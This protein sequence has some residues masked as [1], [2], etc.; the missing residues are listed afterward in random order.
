M[1]RERSGPLRDGNISAATCFDTFAGG[2]AGY[3]SCV[4]SCD[5]FLQHPAMPRK[6]GFL[7]RVAALAPFLLLMSNSSAAPDVVPGRSVV[8]TRGGVVASSQPLA[9]AAAVRILDAGGN[10]AD[11][12]IAA[13]AAVGVMEPTGNGIGGDLFVL[14][15]EAKSGKIFGPNASGR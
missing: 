6:V 1:R 14:Y 11:A 12:A 5:N 15:Y 13:N 8:A 4:K 9:A 2:A 10:A 3:T 7:R